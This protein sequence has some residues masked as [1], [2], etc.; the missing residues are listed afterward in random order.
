MKSIALTVSPCGLKHRSRIR[1]PAEVMLVC[2]HADKNTFTI[3]QPWAF[4]SSNLW[5]QIVTFYYFFSAK[6]LLARGVS[7]LGRPCLRDRLRQ[8]CDLV[9]ASEMAMYARYP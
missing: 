4:F 3:P 8:A 5:A 9:G 2:S 6:M 7:S 1:I